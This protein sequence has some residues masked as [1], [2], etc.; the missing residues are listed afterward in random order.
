MREPARQKT[1]RPPRNDREFTLILGEMVQQQQYLDLN[2]GLQSQFSKSEL[3]ERKGLVKT[4]FLLDARYFETIKTNSEQ[5]GLPVNEA[6]S[7]RPTV[8]V[9][10]WV[11]FPT[12][13]FTQRS[14]FLPPAPR[15]GTQA[16]IAAPAEA[17]RGPASALCKS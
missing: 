9:S 17:G 8:A 1:P 16:V 2:S 7:G 5:N 11:C 12:W 4:Y 10:P 3:S 6:C 15:A 14:S 13:P